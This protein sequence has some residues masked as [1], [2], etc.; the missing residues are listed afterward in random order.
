MDNFYQRLFVVYRD[1]SSFA[2]EAGY[3]LYKGH[4]WLCVN[5]YSFHTDDDCRYWLDNIMTALTG[6]QFDAAEWALDL[7]EVFMEWERYPDDPHWVD[8]E[9][10]RHL[11][12]GEPISRT[13][14]LGEIPGES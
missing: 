6:K 1:F 14:P 2:Q 4:R 3:W 7:L 12:L 5:K 10:A 11:L 9:H 8:L 13:E